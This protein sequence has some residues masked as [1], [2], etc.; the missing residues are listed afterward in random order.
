VAAHLGV[1][2]FVLTSNTVIPFFRLT[3]RPGFEGGR[4]SSGVN[5]QD[6]GRSRPVSRTLWLR[7]LG[8]RG[9]QSM[10]EFVLILP[11][12]L[13]LLFGIIEFGLLLYNK[14]VITN[15]SREGARYGIV[16]RVSRRSP[17]EI[18]AVVSAYVANHLITSGTDTAT[19]TI[20][21]DP[22]GTPQAVFGDD[23][24][25]TVNYHYDFFAL[26]DFITSLL[27]GTDLVAQTTMKYE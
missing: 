14:Q 18:Q 4:G 12:L 17:E 2:C 7:Q 11:V 20:S 23:L 3:G 19:T 6:E 22:S 24:T 8:R 1:P 21:R 25:V 16:A 15:A 10:V 13:I 27:G 5:D 26:P 9:G